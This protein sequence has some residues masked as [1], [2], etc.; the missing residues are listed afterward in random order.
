MRKKM[1]EVGLI[2]VLILLTRRN[3]ELFLIRRMFARVKGM[4][5]VEYYKSLG[6]GNIHIHF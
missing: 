5:Y 2:H 6:H 3:T 4:D 1:F